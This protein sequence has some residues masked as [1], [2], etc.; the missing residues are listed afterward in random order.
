MLEIVGMISSCLF[1]S[2]V[3]LGFDAGKTRIKKKFDQ[4]KLKKALSRYIENHSKIIEADFLDTEIDYQG[5]VVYI[6]NNLINEVSMRI[7][8]LKSKERG[9][10]RDEIVKQAISFINAK[11][12]ETKIRISKFVYECLDVYRDF[13]IKNLPNEIYIISSE[14]VDAVSS[15]IND[16]EN[17]ITNE[18]RNTRIYSL[19]TISKEAGAGEYDTIAKKLSDQLSVAS[20][21][22]PLS[23]YYKFDYQDG[24]LISKPALPEAQKKYPEQ[25]RIR[26]TVHVKNHAF[27]NQHEIEDYA[28]R[29]QAPIEIEVESINKYLGEMKDPIQPD[30]KKIKDRKIYAHP[31]EFPPAFPCSIKI[32]DQ[33]Y[34]DYILLRTQEIKDDETFIINNSEQNNKP[35]IVELQIKRIDEKTYFGITNFRINNRSASHK[36]SLKYARFLKAA[37]NSGEIVIHL[38]EKDEDL[39]RGKIGNVNHNTGFRDIDQEIDFFER[40][41]DLED[42]HNKEISIPAK[43]TNKDYCKFLTISDLTR[44][45][46]NVGKW[47]EMKING[48]VDQ[49]FREIINTTTSEPQRLLIVSTE[50]EDVLGNSIQ[51]KY[52]QDLR[53]AI[54]S[55]IDRL[56]QLVNLLHDGDAITIKLVAGGDCTW[57]KTMNIPEEINNSKK[58]I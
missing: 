28:Y 6:K 37:V 15:Q 11:E 34:F 10:A 39:L 14:V 4:H 7:Y 48:V 51:I 24:E 53:E 25:Y 21:H 12:I 23:P 44:G 45:R 35:V 13:F 31:R 52:M 32:N 30:I 16:A 27:A 8:S 41:C 42:Y 17:R 5:L 22:Y 19:D 43:I 57:V 49:N 55:D 58:Q 20:T 47:R 50:T 9:K 40:I 56:R 29:H 3:E 38:L 2:I 1:D 36:T 33:S 18:V 46:S 26:G 54:I